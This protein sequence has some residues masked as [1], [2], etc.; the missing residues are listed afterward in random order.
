MGNQPTTQLNLF[1]ARVAAEAGIAQA[2][3]S[4]NKKNEKWIETAYAFLR[5]WL[6]AQPREK[7]FFIEEIRVAAEQAGICAPS[8]P[9][10]WGSLALRASKEKL[11]RKKGYGNTRNILAHMTP[12]AIWAR[13]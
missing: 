3:D 13:M 7:L 5:T 12:A 1:S 11:I 10:V 4:T 2:V 9:R 6:Q 8:H